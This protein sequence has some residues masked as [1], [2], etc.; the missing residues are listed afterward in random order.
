MNNR[1][2]SIVSSSLKILKILFSSLKLSLE[3]K[4]LLNI[5][6]WK[7]SYNIA[8]ASDGRCEMPL[9]IPV[10]VIVHIRSENYWD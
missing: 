1:I 7:D 2:S 6:Y 8:K 3:Y 9:V 4:D 10:D 5:L